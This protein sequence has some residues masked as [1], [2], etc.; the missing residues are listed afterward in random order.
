MPLSGG[1]QERIGSLFSLVPL[2]VPTHFDS[3]FFLATVTPHLLIWDLD[4][5]FVTLL[6]VLHKFS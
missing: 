5:N 6:K 2:K 4:L 3:E 1:T